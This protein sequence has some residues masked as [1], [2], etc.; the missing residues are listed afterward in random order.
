MTDVT[1]SEKLGKRIDGIAK[2]RKISR[3][4]LAKE[5]GVPRT[6]LNRLVNESDANP[7]LE[8]LHKLATAFGISVAEL[9]DVDTA[10]KGNSD[11]EALD[12]S[13]EEK[14]FEDF[15]RDLKVAE[16]GGLVRESDVH[17]LFAVLH[18]IIIKNKE[19]SG[20]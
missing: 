16:L 8:T 15:L 18:H 10:L 1:L 6:T 7:S 9:L 19:V 17:L 4:S 2:Q 11:S 14:K 5:V 3:A 20:L 12:F 13:E